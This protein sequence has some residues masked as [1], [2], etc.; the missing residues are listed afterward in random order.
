MMKAKGIDTLADNASIEKVNRLLTGL[1]QRTVRK[2]IRSSLCVKGVY[3]IWNTSM[4][5]S[6]FYQE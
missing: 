4:A 5:K 6:L 3:G 2:S 1:L